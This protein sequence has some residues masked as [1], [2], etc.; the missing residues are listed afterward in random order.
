MPYPA[1]PPGPQVERLVFGQQHADVF[2]SGL[3]PGSLQQLVSAVVVIGLQFNK[4]KVS[5]LV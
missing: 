2:G 3:F 1:A 4:R 5:P